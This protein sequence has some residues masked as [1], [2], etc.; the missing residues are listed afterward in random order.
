MCIRDRAMGLLRAA[1]Q[2]GVQLT[3]SEV[4]S[5]AA[6]GFGAEHAGTLAAAVPQ[7]RARTHFPPNLDFRFCFFPTRSFVNPEGLAWTRAHAFMAYTLRARKGK[8][9]HEKGAYARGLSRFTQS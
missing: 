4:P 1:G 7:V 3:S 8:F 9:R 2:G 5:P 6:E